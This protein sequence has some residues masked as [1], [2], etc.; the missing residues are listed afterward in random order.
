M[1]PSLYDQLQYFA[2][3]FPAPF[4]AHVEINRPEKINAFHEAMW[5]ELGGVFRGLSH[6]PDVRAIMLSGRGEKGFCAGL[7]VMAASQGDILGDS[8]D[9]TKPDGARTAQKLRRHIDEFQGSISE[10][11]K[12][13]KRE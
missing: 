10:V 9:G 8:K 7:D 2:V 5:L 11:E 1:A 4:V 6:D 13:E 12:C 3:S